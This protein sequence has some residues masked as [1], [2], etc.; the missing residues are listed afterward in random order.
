MLQCI[1]WYGSSDEASASTKKKAIALVE[2]QMSLLLSLSDAGD[3]KSCEEAPHH[4]RSAI[5][6]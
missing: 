2:L 6:T 3:V 4:Q 5:P 1:D